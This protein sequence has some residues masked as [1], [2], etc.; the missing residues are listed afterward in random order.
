[1]FQTGYLSLDSYDSDSLLYTLRFPNREVENGFYHLILPLYA[2]D[3][4]R[5]G[6]PFDFVEFRKDLAKGKIHQFM[7]RLQTMLKDLPGNDHNES[8]YRAITFL[9]AVLCGTSV[10]AE[11]DGYKGLSDL[12]VATNRFIYLFEFK[13]NKSVKEAMYQIH[14]RDYHG[15]FA[16]DH[17]KLY[18]IAANFC[19][20]KDHRGLEYEI[21]EA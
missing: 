7:K 9:L 17:R 12:E 13:Y 5:K 8:T 4:D 11:H 18:L 19:E 6:S 3:T 2:P 10:I 1:M 16:M 20:K 15:R 21:A 14:N